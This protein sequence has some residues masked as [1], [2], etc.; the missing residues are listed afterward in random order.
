MLCGVSSYRRIPI[1]AKL[2][3]YIQKRGK[4]VGVVT[5][6]NFRPGAFEQLQQL[7]TEIKVPVYG[8]FRKFRQM[9]QV[10]DRGSIAR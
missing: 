1:T 5:V 6:D 2:A 3:K 7:C 9:L 10:G 8:A 4:K